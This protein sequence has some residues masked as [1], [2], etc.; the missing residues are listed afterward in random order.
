MLFSEDQKGKYFYLHDE[1]R[2]VLPNY[3]AGVFRY[4]KQFITQL[5]LKFC[6]CLSLLS[7]FTGHFLK[8]EVKSLVWVVHFFNDIIGCKGWTSQVS[9][10]SDRHFWSHFSQKQHGSHT[11]PFTNREILIIYFPEEFYD[12]R[13]NK[14]SCLIIK[15]LKSRNRW[16]F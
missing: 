15:V 4:F 11:L 10:K 3:L 13:D 14:F 2:S 1:L 7:L 9:Q 5:L 8:L 6:I 16:F 12:P